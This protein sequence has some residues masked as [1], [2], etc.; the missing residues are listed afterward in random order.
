MEQS[1]II[2]SG[3][4]KMLADFFADNIIRFCN[5]ENYGMLFKLVKEIGRHPCLNSIMDIVNKNRDK[6][7]EI[8]NR[9]ADMP[10]DVLGSLLGLGIEFNVVKEA[11]THGS[12]NKGVPFDCY[13]DI[14]CIPLERLG[15]VC[16]CKDIN[17]S[18]KT[19]C[20]N[21]YNRCTGMEYDVEGDVITLLLCI[22][23]WEVVK[24][25]LENSSIEPV[26]ARYRVGKDVFKVSIFHDSEL[27][28]HEMYP[29]MLAAAILSDNMGAVDYVMDFMGMQKIN[30]Y[31]ST[32]SNAIAAMSKE[33][34]DK[35]LKKYPNLVKEVRLCD[36]LRESN[37]SL[38]EYNMER[39]LGREQY[40]SVDQDDRAEYAEK[41]KFEMDINM[42]GLK[43]TPGRDIREVIASGC[44]WQ[45]KLDFLKKYFE[46]YIP[47][48]NCL[49]GWVNYMDCIRKGYDLFFNKKEERIV[50][51]H[52]DVL[53]LLRQE[54]KIYGSLPARGLQEEYTVL[55][56]LHEWSMHY[57]RYN[58]TAMNEIFRIA[59]QTS[60]ELYYMLLNVTFKIVRADAMRQMDDKM[61][62]VLKDNWI[63]LFKNI[64]MPFRDIFEFFSK[65]VGEDGRL[66]AD[67]IFANLRKNIPKWFITVYLRLKYCLAG[68]EAIR[69]ME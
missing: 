39:Y 65:C 14:L 16:R 54:R 1:E 56:T 61:E 66:T 17:F 23:A 60:V 53:E 50:R 64:K 13:D 33:S 45:K 49:D 3:D 43:M 30:C 24:I 59:G 4:E 69:L 37:V 9:M 7:N 12:R 34:F 58:Y 5:E 42:F 29:G 40:E 32:V 41:L 44:Y 62:A 38:F 28:K 36:A 57:M 19:Q 46:W 48:A 68:G 55:N 20:F 21:V 27:I 15:R 63:Y 6:L 51:L 22:G 26:L 11:Y 31:D 67:N 47:D 52:E 10:D 8:N 35:F 18:T 2:K 25:L